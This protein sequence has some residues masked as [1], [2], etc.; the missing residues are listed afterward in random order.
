MAS[1]FDVVLRT[2][3]SPKY[4]C[5]VRPAQ[6]G[7]TRTMQEMMLEYE[8]LAKMFNP[9]DGTGFLNVVIC[10][11][12]LNLVKQTHA[13]MAE[14]VVP[15][16]TEDEESDNG[17]A[18]DTIEGEIFSW[19]TGT[20]HTNITPDAL[21]GKIILGDVRMVVCCAH[22]KRIQYVVD[23]LALLSRCA[24]FNQ[25]V[26]IWMDEADDYVNLWSEVDYAQFAKVR[27]V[28]LVSAT[29]DAIVERHTHVKVMPFPNTYHTCYHATADSVVE[30]VDI[31]TSGAVDYFE[32]VYAANRDV[33]RRPGVRAFMPGD[34]AVTSHTAIADRLYADGWAVAVIN[35]KRKCILVPGMA[36]PLVIAAHVPEGEIME[37][38]K[39]IA[40]MYRDYNL[41]RFPFAIT[42]KLCLGRGI[43]FQCEE[44]RVEVSVGEG[45]AFESTSVVNFEF[46]FD[47]GII[48]YMS[49]AATLY[50]CV[51]RTNGNIRE[52]VRYAPPKLFMMRA[53]YDK[54]LKSEAIAKN[55]A[56]LVR[57]HGLADIGKEEMD[58]AFHG[59]E[60]T[61]RAD[62]A[63]AAAEANRQQAVNHL[64]E[65][66]SMD[67]LRARWAAILAEAGQE[68]SRSPATPRKKDGMYVCSIGN[69][70]EKQNAREIATKF[71]EGGSVANW[72]SG[73]TT[74]AVGDYIH[75][76]L[77]GYEA[78]GT[79][80][81]FLRWTIKV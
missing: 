46:M 31:H 30:F 52:F 16:S 48:P 57:T 50:Q 25:G 1:P 41:A 20:K 53:T 9:E 44:K 19:M 80:V 35:G 34:D 77:V 15:A 17:S 22:K 12:N 3:L 64:E 70:S 54:I 71:P 76:V 60:E 63:R 27:G 79:V 42:G 4:Q 73:L 45:G 5:L 6:S 72:G 55:L 39:T 21:F 26:N 7:K 59:N 32:K 33:L 67:A 69:H 2:K 68:N 8:T 49:N 62:L 38:G 56:V 37:I 10:S 61:Y 66:P 43:T 81:F 28:Y 74:A 51:S 18:D 13:R 58:W 36:D 78:D 29:I 24:F 47:F 40:R 14:I 75:R 23:L 65:F 11:K